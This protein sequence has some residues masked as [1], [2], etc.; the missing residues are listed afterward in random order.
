MSGGTYRQLLRVPGVTRLMLSS[1]A[2]GIAGTMVPV[3]FVLFARAA[4]GSFASASAVLAASTAGGLV[5]APLRGRLVDRIGPSPAVL[6]LAVPSVATDVAFILAGT[7]GASVL[8]LSILAFVAGAITTPAGAALRNVLSVQLASSENRQAGYAVMSMLQEASFIT[9][10]LLAG[11]L[12][13]LWTPTA[14]VALAAGLSLIGAVMF[15]TSPG[16]RAQQP[17]PRQPGRAAALAGPGIRT[18]IATSAAFGLTFGA[19]D[20]AFPAFAR[21]HGS[22][23]AAGVLLS[24]L[25]AG[26]GVGGFLYGRRPD[27]GPPG[28][29]YSM[30]A[31]LAAAGLLP[32]VAASSLPAMLLLAF[33]SG[34][35]FAP[36][37]ICQIA[38]IDHVAPTGHTAEA[39]TWLTTL[40]G[41]GSALGAALA[42]QLIAHSGIRAAIILACATTFTAWVLAMARRAKLEPTPLR[43][44]D[45][46]DCALL[47]LS[48]DQ[49]A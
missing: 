13:A 31:L 37:T 2:L 39:F 38:I 4:T 7:T 46:H 34:L 43:S 22:T 33:A 32:L 19:L 41:A 17:H 8:L 5:F 21:D 24:A 28:R 14:A 1:L 9:G 11:G 25:A 30:L 45:Q 23:A 18:V 20:L 36:I 27:T 15:A 49:Q 12:I 6:R 47:N 40:Y 3:S 10:P 29:R 16:A 44:Q 26:I 48:T 35:C 42:G